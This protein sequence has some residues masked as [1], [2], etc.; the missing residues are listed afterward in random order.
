MILTQKQDP[1]IAIE[2]TSSNLAEVINSKA[3]MTDKQGLGFQNWHYVTA[4]AK[5]DK[6]ASY[7]QVCLDSGC[8]MTLVN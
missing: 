7:N 6:N 5:L 3:V 1:P 4:L 2:P 8:T